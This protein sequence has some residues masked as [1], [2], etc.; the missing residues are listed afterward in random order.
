MMGKG[1][2]TFQNA[3]NYSAGADATSVAVGDLN[4]DGKPDLVFTD[5]AGNN[6]VVLLNSFIPGSS[7]AVCTAVPQAPPVSAANP[8]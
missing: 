5:D 7:A 1:D 6:L 3:L 8:F 4:A 2:G